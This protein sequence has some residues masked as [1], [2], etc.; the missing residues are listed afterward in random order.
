MTFGLKFLFW[1]NRNFSFQKT[2]FR[3]NMFFQLQYM[4]SCETILVKMLLSKG[5]V[6]SEITVQTL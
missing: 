6:Q 1:K 5:W 3:Y 4:C 2:P